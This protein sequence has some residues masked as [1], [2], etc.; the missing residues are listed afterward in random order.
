M[1]Q[2][3]GGEAQILKIENVILFE[4]YNNNNLNEKGDYFEVGNKFIFTNNFLDSKLKRETN[5]KD[6]FDTFKQKMKQN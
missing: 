4:V 6:D 2:P 3:T 5:Y 1:F